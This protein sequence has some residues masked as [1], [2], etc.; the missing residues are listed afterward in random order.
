MTFRNKTHTSRWEF[1]DSY[2]EDWKQR[3]VLL[4][5]LFKTHEYV[6]GSKNQV[7]EYGCGAY[8]PFHNLFHGEDGF[9][10]SKYDIKAWDEETNVIDLNT[11]EPLL[12]TSNISI[13][14]G[15]LEYLNDVPSI[16]RKAIEA[17]DYLLVSYAFMP[18]ALFLDEG[19][20]LNS[21]NNRAVNNGWR[22]HYTNKDLVELISTIGVL[23]AVDVWNQNQSLF[24]IRN[25]KLDEL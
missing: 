4:M 20:F 23:S 16:L 14:S 17:S 15:V 25:P 19:K 13:F 5:E 11:T 8:A 2:S 6:E 24:L 1:A 10:V 3:A 9:K 18:S 21:I 7:V 12:P 22:N